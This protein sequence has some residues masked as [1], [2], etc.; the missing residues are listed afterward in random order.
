MDEDDR[1]EKG[2]DEENEDVEDEDDDDEDGGEEIESHSRSGSIQESPCSTQCY[3]DR[4]HHHPH[5]WAKQS[6]SE[7]GEDGFLVE[8]SISENSEG[9]GESEVGHPQT[10]PSSPLCEL[11]S[12]GKMPEVVGQTVPS[13]TASTAGDLLPVGSQDAVV[14]HAT[15]EE[16]RSLE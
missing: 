9:E 5:S 10:P 8:L 14:I 13:E 3:S 2:R 15:E 16:L 12:T 1:E 6:E 4:C 7:N 11:E